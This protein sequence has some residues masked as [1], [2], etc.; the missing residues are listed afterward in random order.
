MSKN[1][2]WTVQ[3]FVSQSNINVNL[4]SIDRLAMFWYVLYVNILLVKETSIK[5]L[6]TTPTYLHPSPHH[7]H[8]I[9]ILQCLRNTGPPFKWS[10]C[11]LGRFWNDTLNRNNSWKKEI[12]S[13][14]LLALGRNACIY[15]SCRNTDMIWLLWYQLSIFNWPSMISWAKHIHCLLLVWIFSNIP[16]K[17]NTILKIE[18]NSTLSAGSWPVRRV[19]PSLHSRAWTHHTGWSGRSHQQNIEDILMDSCKCEGM[20]LVNC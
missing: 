10:I 17:M 5:C 8:L 3:L 14:S 2:T 11:S 12:L 16:S 20:S 9:P 19:C 6:Q 13:S 7:P 18:K 4:F 15:A 1:K